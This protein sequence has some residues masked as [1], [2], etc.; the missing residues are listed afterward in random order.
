MVKADAVPLD[1]SPLDELLHQVVDTQEQPTAAPERPIDDSAP[2]SSEKESDEPVTAVEKQDVERPAE[3]QEESPSPVLSTHGLPP[4]HLGHDSNGGTSKAQSTD[5]QSTEDEDA[6]FDKRLQKRT[7]EIRRY[8]NLD[9]TD[10][11]DVDG[12]GDL[13]RYKDVS[14]KSAASL[15]S[16]KSDLFR[17]ILDTRNVRSSHDRSWFTGSNCGSRC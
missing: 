7:V 6:K 15:P 2:A 1:S 16:T 3:R 8:L 13:L 11:N 14:R 4:F 9:Y 10:Y 17:Q 5:D 12:W